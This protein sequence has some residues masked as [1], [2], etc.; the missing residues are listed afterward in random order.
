MGR[1]IYLP[2]WEG[3]SRKE[4][5]GFWGYEFA[6]D[7]YLWTSFKGIK[8]PTG[9]GWQCR[10]EL[11]GTRRAGGDYQKVVALFRLVSDDPLYE[12]GV[13]IGITPKTSWPMPDPINQ[14]GM[15]ADSA[16]F[17]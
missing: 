5:A 16:V 3:G 9:D 11:E 13:S 6:K 17:I 12:C 1:F 14:L 8:L 7:Q 4:R 10:L 15:T 2:N